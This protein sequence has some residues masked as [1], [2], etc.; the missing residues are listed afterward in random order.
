[1]T[2][3]ESAHWVRRC[4]PGA[5]PLRQHRSSVQEE[6]QCSQ[7]RWFQVRPAGDW[8]LRLKANFQW[9]GAWGISE[10]V[11]CYLSVTGSIVCPRSQGWQIII[12]E[13][14]RLPVV[15][16]MNTLVSGSTSRRRRSARLRGL[17]WRRIA[18]QNS[19][20]KMH[21]RRDGWHCGAQVRAWR[22]ADERDHEE[23]GPRS[24]CGGAGPRGTIS[25]WPGIGTSSH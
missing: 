16:C 23:V 7:N 10:Q 19:E 8:K 20:Q 13:G 15:Q 3:Y 21:V 22:G 18:A 4:C 2:L 1:M 6:R 14:D 24:A 5:V 9:L 25:R 11:E 17:L 12:G